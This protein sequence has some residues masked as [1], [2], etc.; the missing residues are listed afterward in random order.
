MNFLKSFNNKLNKGASKFRIGLNKEANKCLTGYLKYQKLKIKNEKIRFK[1]QEKINRK[2][3]NYNNN[4]N[5]E[6]DDTISPNLSVTQGV[7]T[8]DFIDIDG[9]P[10][11]KF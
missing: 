8:G 10:F 4:N 5:N 9:N 7:F 6:D 3:R 1:Y 11:T 2:N